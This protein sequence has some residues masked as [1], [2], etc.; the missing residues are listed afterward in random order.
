MIQSRPESLLE[1][2]ERINKLH[3]IAYGGDYESFSQQND[4]K[5]NFRI[6]LISE[7]PG[8]RDALKELQ[9]RVDE[10]EEKLEGA[11]EFCDYGEDL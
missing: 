1:L 3:L 9:T 6:A 4:A 5:L 11:R 10:L 7:W 8:L 2:V